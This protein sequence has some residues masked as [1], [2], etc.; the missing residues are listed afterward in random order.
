VSFKKIKASRVNYPANS[1]VGE[2]GT[3]FYDEDTGDFR[4]VDGEIP[5]GRIL[6]PD[7]TSGN[8]NIWIGNIR[9]EGN[10]NVVGTTVTE[11]TFTANNQNTITGTLD[12]TGNSTFVGE[13]VFNGPTVFIGDMTSSGARV[14]NG[15]A[16]FNGNTNINGD[17]TI[18][19]NTDVTGN[20]NI[21]GPSYHLGQLTLTGNLVST[22]YTRISNP[23]VTVTTPIVSINGNQNGVGLASITGGFVLQTIGVNDAISIVSNDSYGANARPAFL[24]RRAR[25]N[26]AIASSVQANDVLLRLVSTG[27]T[28]AGFAAVSTRIDSVATENYSNTAQGSKMQFGVVATGTNVY[29]IS[30]TIDSHGLVTGNVTANNLLLANS[31]I[32]FDGNVF[33]G[34]PFNGQR[35]VIPTEQ[36]FVLGANLTLGGNTALQSL[37]GVGPAVSS[38]TRYW[39]QIMATVSKTSGT[40]STLSYAIGG[41]AVLSKHSFTVYSAASTDISVPAAGTG[42]F[43]YLT[44]GFNVGTVVT[45]E[46]SNTVGAAQ[47]FIFGIMEVASGGTVHPQISFSTIPGGASTLA[48]SKMCIWPMGSG[49]IGNIAIGSWSN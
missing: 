43:K 35:G 1:W 5:G 27:Y 21:I 20:L 46:L 16:T 19:G 12:V 11:N 6:L 2:Y 38:N 41:N 25:G 22:G 30:A 7:L 24:G 44:S 49:T 9:V 33:V 40:S 48:L 28:P 3:L 36:I 8:G 32:A 37:L 10:L 13:T 17:L 29:A 26:L 45:G 31:A 42:M 4:I 34:T 23:G 15:T 18:S 14:S 47:L 39:Y